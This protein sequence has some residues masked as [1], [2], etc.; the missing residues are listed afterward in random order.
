MVSLCT[1]VHNLYI[2]EN[3]VLQCLVHTF[4]NENISA[5]Y[6]SFYGSGCSNDGCFL[7]FTLHRD[8]MFHI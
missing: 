1:L 4:G 3:A 7:V 2:I 6:T 8:K 5:Y